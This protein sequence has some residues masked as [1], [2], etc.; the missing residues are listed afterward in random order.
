MTVRLSGFQLLS[1]DLPATLR[2]T[3]D[4]EITAA[5]NIDGVVGVSTA[6]APTPG[7]APAYTLGGTIQRDGQHDP[8]HHPHDQRALRRNLVVQHLQLRRE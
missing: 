3:V 1:S 2:E 4:A 8:C 6:S 5:F 7:A